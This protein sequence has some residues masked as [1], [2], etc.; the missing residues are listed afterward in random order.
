MERRWNSP[1]TAA[2]VWL[3]PAAIGL[4]ASGGYERE[5]LAA[6]CAVELTAH[7]PNGL[8]TVHGVLKRMAARRIAR[9]KADILL[10]DQAMAVAVAADERMAPRNRLLRSVP[11]VGPVFAHTLLALM[12]ELGHLTRRRPRHCSAWL[13]STAKAE[14]S[15]DND[16]P[17]AAANAC[18][19]PPTWQP[20]SPD[21]TIL[22]SKPSG[23]V[24]ETG[25]P[26]KVILIAIM[27]KLICALNAMINTINH[28]PPDKTVTVY[29]S[30][31]RRRM[32][33]ISMPELTS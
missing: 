30:V 24:A 16:A 6:Q 22:S 15:G 11:G 32:D 31:Q 9:L 17:S 8:R 7:R 4:E 23:S 13:P 5:A 12:P 10:I 2:L 26:P 3:G 25:Q 14:H 28:G 27:R 21:S 33:V 18:A 20:L 29:L 1:V 19:M